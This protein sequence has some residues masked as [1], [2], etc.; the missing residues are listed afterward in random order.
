MPTPET[1]RLIAII[2]S[3][4]LL[5]VSL[6]NPLYGMLAYLVI[7]MTR[8]G[9]YYPALANVRIELIFALV[10]VIEAIITKKDL[11]NKIRFQYNAVNK[12][13]FLFLLV[14]M[15]SFAQAWDYSVSWNDVV[16]EFLKIYVLFL[17]ILLLAESERDVR[18]T[19]WTFA[20]ATIFLGYEG[21]YLYIHGGET[22]IFRGVDV[23]I[24]SEGFASGHVA[25]A[26]MQLQGLPIMFYLVFAEKRLVLKG[27]A[28]LLAM[29]S[30]LGVIASGS[31]GGFLGLIVF[32]ALTVYFSERKGLALFICVTIFFLSIPFLSGTYLSWMESVLHHTDDSAESRITGLINGIEMMM[33]RPILGVGPG[34]YPL[35]RKAWFHWGLESH[36]Q[37][38]QM[39]GDLGLLGTIAWGFFFFGILRNLKLAKEAFQ[40]NRTRNMVYLVIG[41]QIALL[42]RLFEGMFSQ[43]LYIFF[44]YMIA[45]LSIVLLKESLA[46]NDGSNITQGDE[47]VP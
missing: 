22:Y 18:I 11:G 46:E 31:R 17:M 7:M 30:V 32:A 14:I 36:N 13:M 28:A 29:L 33:R 40:K 26:N 16:I 21:I 43:S 35:A 2:G 15:A 45:A 19:L 6:R 47:I 42:V 3:F 41:I 24:A 34:C 8:P 12:Y 44:W 37:F 38:G 39:M 1:I 5:L 20:I 4:F 9:L 23:A 25:A 10:V 27:S